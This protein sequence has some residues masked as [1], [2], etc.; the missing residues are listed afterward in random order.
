MDQK[1]LE[2]FLQ[3]APDQARYL[4][5][6]ARNMVGGQGDSS[7]LIAAKRVAHTL[8]GSGAIIGLRGLA[9]LG[10]HFEDILEHFERQGGQV[11]KPAADALLDAAYCLEQM[12]GYV[13][14][15]DEYPQQAQAVLQDVLDLANRIDRGE[16]VDVAISRAAMAPHPAQGGAAWS[17]AAPVTGGA[18]VSPTAALRVSV[19][20]SG[21]AVPRFRRGF[22]AHR[23]HGSAHQDAHGTARASC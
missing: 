2:G 13:A 18:T 10:H 17:G 20:A 16:S 22:G 19:R 8:K 9:S 15:S 21:R 5:D 1:L 4:V 6:L 12:V 14:G 7:D 23:G 11:A 3:E